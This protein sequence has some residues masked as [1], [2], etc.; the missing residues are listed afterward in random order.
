MLKMLLWGKPRLPMNPWQSHQQ[1]PVDGLR[2]WHP[3]D[4]SAALD[5]IGRLLPAAEAK[6]RLQS[7]LQRLDQPLHS[8]QVDGKL[9]GLALPPGHICVVEPAHAA[10]LQMLATSGRIGETG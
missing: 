7:W 9:V 1:P 6:A 5:L 8:Y 3:A 4:E 2:P 10:T